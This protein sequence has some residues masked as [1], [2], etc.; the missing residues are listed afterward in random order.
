[1]DNIIAN[2][3]EKRSGYYIFH[4]DG[5]DTAYYPESQVIFV[6]DESGLIAVKA[7]ATR[8]TLFLLRK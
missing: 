8:K 1:M 2:S 4:F 5:N 6:D 7:T 3:F